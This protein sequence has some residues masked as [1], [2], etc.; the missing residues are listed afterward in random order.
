[1]TVNAQAAPAKHRS[2][3]ELLSTDLRALPV[4]IA[5]IVLCIVFASQNGVFLTPRN[6]SNL[7]VQS[8]IVG[9]MSIG[10]IFILLIKE[11]DLSFAA[12]N[13]VAAVLMAKLVVE[14]GAPPWAAIAL[15]L[16]AGAAIA[17]LSALC[18]N[19]VGVPSFIVTLGLGLALNGLQLILLPATARYDLINT[20]IDKIAQTNI[21][22]WAAW[23]TLAIGLA[24]F[25]ILKVSSALRR[26][27]A[28][29][30]AD[31]LKSVGLPLALA[32]LFGAAFV[33]VLSLHQG[34]PLVVL[35]FAALLGIGGY[36]LG[37][38][39]FGLYLYALG[40]N[41]EATRRAGVKVAAL[42]VAAFAIGGG[43]AALA[44]V[45]G[46]SRAL[47]AGVFSGGGVGGG[48]LLLESIAATVIGGVSLFGGR[49][50]IHAALLGA[51]II[52]TV[53]N[54]LNLMGVPNEVRLIVT[55]LMLLLAV[56]LDKVIE[57]VTGQQSF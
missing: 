44:G 32:A 3:G 1:M 33:W 5:L 4:T 21:A 26:R 11:I 41:E 45:I 22:G 42:R 55:G 19:L 24:L 31:M 10:L 34:I 47:S 52:G 38:T 37:E 53:A 8:T 23:A 6:I 36:I 56:S 7:L 18:V 49:G 27:R 20:G 25:A 39:R 15:A 50:G 29:L 30:E 46:A 35:I 48:T 57:R 12:I 43:I 14:F 13:G 2:L 40:N 16:T 17:S 9:I 51:L 54:G 28:G